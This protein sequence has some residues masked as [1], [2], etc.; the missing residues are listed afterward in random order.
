MM[1]TLM[2]LH[3]A[4]SHPYTYPPISGMIIKQWVEGSAAFIPAYP[5]HLRTEAKS[6]QHRQV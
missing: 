4:K 2:G 5:E 6:L 1:L 3:T